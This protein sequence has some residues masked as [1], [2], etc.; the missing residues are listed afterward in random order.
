M[1]VKEKISETLDEL[2][3]SN[4]G[5]VL[6]F[7]DILAGKSFSEMKK[8]AEKLTRFYEESLENSLKQLY[9]YAES[10]KNAINDAEYLEYLHIMDL[11]RKPQSSLNKF[12]I[13]KLFSVYLDGIK[14]NYGPFTD[15]NHKIFYA[16]EYNLN[17]A[18]YDK[19]ILRG[20]IARIPDVMLLPKKVRLEREIKEKETQLETIKSFNKNNFSFAVNKNVFFQN[21]AEIKSF[22]KKL[23]NFGKKCELVIDDDGQIVLPNNSKSEV[24]YSYNSS[25]MKMFNELIEKSL[26]ENLWFSE[27]FEERFIPTN[28]SALWSYDYVYEANAEKKFIASYMQDAKLSPFETVL[29]A[30]RQITKSKYIGTATNSEKSRTFLTA[31][32]ARVFDTELMP[33]LAFVCTGYASFA[34]AIMDEIGNKN[35]KTTLV[36]IDFYYKGTSRKKYSATHLAVL[37]EI[38]DEKY[39]I[40]GAYIWDPTWSINTLDFVLSPI[41]DLKKFKKIYA[42]IDHRNKSKI[43]KFIVS[44]REETMP[45]DKVI[46]S[47]YDEF[48]GLNNAIPL[49]IYREALGEVFNK[50]RGLKYF[51]EVHFLKK[52]NNELIDSIFNET[53]LSLTML[54]PENADNSFYKEMRDYYLKHEKL[55]PKWSE[56][57]LK[58]NE[59]HKLK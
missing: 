27:F 6:R 20:I 1:A 34:K 2:E 38:K 40:D 47:V 39:A 26:V 11:L 33:E 9:F 17:D 24:P 52:N 22:L 23:T 37:I 44:P 12:E 50:L 21:F 46:N 45:E 42:N 30:N 54:S 28:R 48:I 4:S 7:E 51:S 18:I 36:P 31:M 15:N 16:E 43:E 53:A 58:Y 8:V 32:D 55:Y 25:Q 19:D 41:S 56:N 5:I 49:A 35:I 59:N 3:N 57:W 10:D 14:H 13:E 29:E